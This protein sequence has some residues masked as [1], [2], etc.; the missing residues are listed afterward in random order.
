MYIIL[1]NIINYYNINII[2]IGILDVTRYWWGPPSCQ[3][4]P[5]NVLFLTIRNHGNVLKVA[6]STFLETMA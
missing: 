3:F 2:V 4:T 1:Y 5:V 6:T